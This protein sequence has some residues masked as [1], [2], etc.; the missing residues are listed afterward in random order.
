LEDREGNLWV[1]TSGGG[2]HRVK[3][4]KLRVVTTA[5]GLTHNVVMSLAQDSDG[6]VW[7]GSNGGGLTAGH[8]M[9]VAPIEAASSGRIQKLPTSPAA[10]EMEFAPAD[11]SYLLD[12]ESI[13][14]VLA[15]RDGVLWLGT[16]NSG[17]F[18]KTGTK[19]EQFHLGRP[20]NEQ[21]VLALCEAAAG[22][23]WVGT[24]QDGLKFFKD[25]AFTS[26][27]GTNGVQAG[28]ITALVMDAAGRLWIGTGGDGLSCWFNGQATRWTAQDGLAGDFIRALY[29][30]REG[31]LWI[32]MN[33]GLSRMKNGRV[34]AITARQ[35]LWNDTISQIL[36]DDQG[37]LWFGC[38][39]GIFCVSK[40]ELERVADGYSAMLTP[41]IYGRA[42]GM[43]SL[44][45]TGGFCPAGL[46]T[47]DGRLWFSTVKGVV[48]VD[49]KNIPVN[50]VAP[51]VV[52]EELRVNGALAVA[53]VSNLVPQNPKSATRN[54]ESKTGLLRNPGV[55]IGPGAR[56]V[57]FRYTA[58]SFTA[59][60]RVR[61]RYR[62]DGLDTDWVD[63]GGRR[64]AEYPHLPPGEYRF[65]VIAC[66]E[67]L[68]WSE[69]EAGLALICRA[70]FWQ[71]GCGWTVK[72]L[73]TRR[74]RRRL[75]V[76]QQQHALEQERTRI[77]RDI[78]DELGTL[79]TGIS[80]LSDRS[81]THRDQPEQV[82]EHLHTISQRA[83]SAVQAVDGIVWAI[84][85]QNDRF[86]HLANYLVQF[87]EGFFR[88]TPIRCRLEVPE[89]VP[90]IP[91]GTQERHH[92]LLAVKE[93]C[94]NVARHSGA[95]EVW[96][97]LKADASDL[98]ITIE[99]N[100]C[101][102]VAGTAA[103]GG[104]GLRNMRQR[105][106]EVGGRLELASEP[107]RGTRVKLFAPL[108]E[109]NSYPC[110]SE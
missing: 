8:P 66:N 80:M 106:A 74:L 54:L 43:E 68:F 30:D 79:L 109:F 31:Q 23:L 70:A 83:R 107:G 71:T 28:F 75:A 40:D 56:R 55:T 15:A 60:E 88:L 11:V 44:E 99:D 22:G 86:D 27:R 3:P 41:V 97:R 37:R 103:E 61:F 102:F 65:R 67:D 13:P 4:K 24:Y 17:L 73:A 5:D 52:I 104:D 89:D 6:D 91:L 33:G 94:N 25:G 46:K 35:G 18:R 51:D 16:W 2:L 32:G 69:R 105:M 20:E 95:S 59:P 92:I 38:N 87:A 90:H 85:P 47:R 9:A 58:L 78:H 36:E 82:A 12:N 57:E 29:A 110:P 64:V 34:T 108:R 7:I 48:I 45:C 14:S 76:I 81:Q 72:L 10:L 77:A 19:L 101:G 1:G 100:G 21:P 42:E 63:A 84:N 26:Y 98:C 96:V 39:R 50:A 53:D 49:P 93:A 62:L